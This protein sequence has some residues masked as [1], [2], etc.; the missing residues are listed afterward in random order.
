LVVYPVFQLHEAGLGVVD[1]VNKLE[2][3]MIKTA[4]DVGVSA[5]RDSRNH[6]IWTG[7]RKIGFVGIAVRRGVSFHGISLNVDLSL[8]PF[9]WIDPCGLRNI[10]VTSLNIESTNAVEMETVKKV[11][12][13]HLENIFHISLQRVDTDEIKDKIQSKPS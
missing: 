5:T 12:R 13:N 9:K 7:D 6:G 11:L 2:E 1:F 3:V 4:A 8:E 10:Q